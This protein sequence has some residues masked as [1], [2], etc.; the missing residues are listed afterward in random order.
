M[1]IVSNRGSDDVTFIDVAG[2]HVIATVPVG[3]RPGGMAVN[4]RGT[5][6]YVANNDSGT[7][8]IVSIPGREV[9]GTIKV[10]RTPDGLA[11]VPRR[12]GA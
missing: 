1:A 8:S 9:S 2:R 11:F 5:R 10:G 12:E 7:V 3:R 6:L 4:G